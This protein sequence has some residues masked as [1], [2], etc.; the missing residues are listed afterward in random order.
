MMPDI[1]DLLESCEFTRAEFLKTQIKLAEAMETASIG[2][3]SKKVK[4]VS[5]VTCE[6]S[7]AELLKVDKRD[8]EEP[9]VTI[10]HQLDEK[11]KCVTTT[12]KVEDRK[13]PEAEYMYLS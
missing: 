10:S 12:L 11:K 1:E 6:Q 7:D 13:D 3:Y 4:Y 8:S 2:C 5:E 9:D